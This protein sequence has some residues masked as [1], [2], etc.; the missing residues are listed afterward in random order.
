MVHALV[1]FWNGKQHI[2][3]AKPVPDFC[4]SGKRETRADLVPYLFKTAFKKHGD[5]SQET[6]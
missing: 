2:S 1:E 4:K 5:I 3:S 6:R